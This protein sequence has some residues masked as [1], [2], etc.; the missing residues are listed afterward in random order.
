MDSFD[1]I[2]AMTRR[3]MLL[4]ALGLA[5][6][7]LAEEDSKARK[8]IKVTGKVN[9]PGEFELKD[10]MRVF[11]S[12]ALARG[13]LDFA[14]TRNILIVRGTER[15]KFSYKLFIQGKRIEENILLMSGDVV[16]VN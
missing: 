12:L 6:A 16:I 10:G 2:R 15:H 14:D 7:C 5:G 8:T 9:Q 13:F 11:D 3:N 1:T 4:F